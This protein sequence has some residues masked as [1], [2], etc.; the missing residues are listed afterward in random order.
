MLA[1]LSAFALA[2]EIKTEKA[3]LAA[4]EAATKAKSAEMIVAL[5]HQEGL[6]DTD[7]AYA[8]ELEKQYIEFAPGELESVAL[9]PLPEDFNPLM[10]SQG[11]KAVMTVAPTG[12]VELK[13][14]ETNGSSE[15][16][17]PYAIVRGSYYLVGSKIVDLN[18]KG[19][20]DQQLSIQI[21]GRG[22]AGKA[23]VKY[24]A[25]GVDLTENTG[26]QAAALWGQY[27]DEVTL[28]SE[29]P[30]AEITLTLKEGEKEIFRSAPLKGAGKIQYLRKK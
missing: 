5:F 21:G 30:K 14:K 29:D 8:V 11:K 13:F 15:T 27:F 20:P 6:S 19:P 22:S 9:R 4:I 1:G 16:N 25:S 2:E 24:N 12:V 10:V 18:W 17:R 28:I 23:K 7:K 3:F 26:G